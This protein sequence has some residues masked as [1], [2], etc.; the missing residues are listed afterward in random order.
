[1]AM[2]AYA[3]LPASFADFLIA[4]VAAKV[5][6]AVEVSLWR[7]ATAN[8]GEFDGIT[9]ILEAGT[10]NDVTATTVTSANVIAE[11][12]SLMLSHQPFTEKKIFIF[13]FHKI[14]QEHTFVL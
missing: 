11:V 8:A 9:T 5:A 4:Q 12:K 14:W 2:S 6:D 10:T 7:G 3:D 1:M 13:T